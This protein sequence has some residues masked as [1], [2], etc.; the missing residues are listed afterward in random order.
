MYSMQA[1]EKMDF[2]THVKIESAQGATDLD[3]YP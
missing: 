2:C 1:R 3:T